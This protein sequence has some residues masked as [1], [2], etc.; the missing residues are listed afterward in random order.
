[1]L[2]LQMV[3]LL[4]NY[5]KHLQMQETTTI[6]MK[7]SI[8]NDKSFNNTKLQVLARRYQV[9]ININDEV[10]QV[11]GTWNKIAEFRK[12]LNEE[13]SEFLA[14]N[15]TALVTLQADQE[16]EN[17]IDDAKSSAEKGIIHVGSLNNDVLALMEKCGIYKYDHLTY[18]TEGG[19]VI[20]SCPGDEDTAS[21]IADAFQTEYRQL[22]MG[23][24][25]KEF[26]FPILN[27][28][29]KQNIE[30]LVMKFNNDYPQSVFKFDQ[31][32]K[33]IKCLSM[34][35]RQIGHIRAKVKDLLEK[36]DDA[37]APASDS[38][39]DTPTSMSLTLPGGRR[40]TLKQ[41]DIVEE[42]V[43]VIVNAANERLSHDG[44]VAAAIDKASYYR[45]QAFSTAL[46]QQR[47]NLT[48]G[49]VVYTE[50]G[51]ALKCKYVI[52][53]VGP[54][55]YKHGEQCQHLLW[56][57]CMNTLQLAGHLKATSLA[58]PPISTGI[59]GVPKDLVAKTIIQ[60]VCSY[61]GY[62]EG[63][64]Q[65]IRIVIID[66]E[67]YKAFQPHF[68]DMRANWSAGVA[69]TRPPIPFQQNHS[70]PDG[71]VVDFML[72]VNIIKG[73]LHWYC[74]LCGSI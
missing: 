45:I 15:T 23:G 72:A 41:A 18:D 28:N 1:M 16:Q 55:G 74:F 4:H 64:L 9:T 10:L 3:E 8:F 60:A 19:R 37:T 66:K 51:G 50:A 38:V 59:F 65:D 53:T 21:R 5:S 32:N 36:P 40:V 46:V 42:A 71:K 39:G 20:I 70:W 63:T 61:P 14:R 34:N 57:A 62:T 43:D 58:M 44:G 54:E 48:T 73:A 69:T 13:I 26:S 33:V 67:T 11:T 2:M 30:Q 7:G 12:I 49:Q 52:H 17:I 6:R 47:G 22:M 29:N 35:A 27:V 68:I 31:E 56:T 25:L 24:K